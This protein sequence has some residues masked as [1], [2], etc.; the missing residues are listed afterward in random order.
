MNTQLR[1]ALAAVTGATVLLVASC[2]SSSDAAPST[3]VSLTASPWVKPLDPGTPTPASTSLSSA[4][5]GPGSTLALAPQSTT[6]IDTSARSLFSAAPLPQGLSSEQIAESE[7][8]IEIYGDFR[9]LTDLILSEPEVD[10][11]S[12]L[13]LLATGTAGDLVASAQSSMKARN[14]HAVGST[15]GVV[16][17]TS[18]ESGL[19]NLSVCVDASQQDLLDDKGNS[20]RRPDGPGSY[21]RFISS[22]Q[23]A[24][25]ADQRWRVAVDTTDRSE[26]C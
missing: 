8:A 21:Y 15:S 10:R 4:P 20:Y 12:E 9:R 26:Q 2:S 24:K 7:A 19:V 1:A 17:V 6:D 13:G 23:V 14:L 18:V 5:E 11:S 3:V 25:F 16:T 22:V